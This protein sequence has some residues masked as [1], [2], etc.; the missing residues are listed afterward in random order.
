M[1]LSTINKESLLSQHDDLSIV[2]LRIEHY[3]G[4]VLGIAYNAPRVSWTYTH[5][6]PD[7]AKVRLLLRR[8]MPGSEAE[9][10]AITVSSKK[11]VLIEWPFEPLKSREEAVLTAQLIAQDGTALGP[12]CDPLYFEAGLFEESAHKADFVGPSWPE[13]ESDHRHLPLVRTETNLKEPPRRAR[14]YLS[15]LG[16]VE[17]EINGVK[18][19]NDALTPGWTVYSNRV[20]C[21]TYDVTDFLVEG[22]NALGFWLGDGWYRGRLGF[23]GGI[24]NYYGNR[25]GVSAQLEIEYGDH[26]IEYVYSNAWD[27]NWK[28][29]LGPIVCS[30]LYEGEHYDARLQMAGWSQPGFDDDGW[31]PVA[32]VP[33]DPA[34]IENPEMGAVQKMEQRAPVMI[35]PIGDAADAKPVW[36]VDMGQNCTQRI[37]LHMHDLRKDD[38]VTLHHVEVLEPDGSI[39]TRTLRRGQQYDQYISNG[40]DAW[41]EPRFTM[42]GFRYVQIEGI[43]NLS[44]KDIDCHVYHSEMKPIGS[45]ETSNDLL[46]KL[47][48]NIV[49]SMRSNFVSIPTDCPQRDE[50]MGWTGDICLFAPT[51]TYLY[52]IQGFLNSWLT[53]VAY[54]RDKW[55]TVPYFIPF[56]PLGGWS[57][58]DALA[59]WG[60]AAV[61]VPWSLFME[62]GDTEKLATTYALSCAWVD[63]V[64]GYLSPDGVWDRRPSFSLGQLGDW[65]DP[66]A[67][68]DNPAQAMTQKE[69][70]ATAFYARSCRQL[71]QMAQILKKEED[72]QR[73]TSLAEHVID[74]FNRRFVGRDGL[75]TSD[76]QCAYALSIEFDLLR[77]FEDVIRAGNRLAYL[78]D[79]SDGKVCTG[80]AGTPYVLP[81][82]SKTGHDK[83]AYA[84][85]ESTVCP[86]WLY[87]VKMGGTTTWE[88]WDSMKPDGS[89]N[90]G[91]MTSFNH[92]ALGSVANWMHTTIG[93]LE[94]IEPGWREFRVAPH[95]GGGI[96]HAS[97]SHITPRGEAS[98]SWHCRKEVLDLHIEVPVGTT[99][100]VDIPSVECSR[101]S[102]GSHDISVHDRN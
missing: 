53:D 69:L 94:A 23:D 59:I 70:V 56:V 87:Q 43:A 25:I 93:G 32:E 96:T 73:Y 35:K 71:T 50:R 49:W 18:V 8:R 51:V 16:M 39:A 12:V 98:V 52:D 30:D 24:A 62:S 21:W 84:L 22:R 74:G 66:S 101:L 1:A 58:P 19:G 48:E 2:D 90:P 29:T 7:K 92:Y 60:D 45:F 67:P 75:M 86:S 91:G 34:H 72:L 41:W 85:L 88:R 89:L 28:T 27:R 80:F 47:H 17:A 6:L 33:Y 3:A 5:D 40:E 54:E 42:H 81:A 44:E 97:T 37:R 61:A 10:I 38:V 9:T 78:V 11:S 76:T 102:P 77:R 4:N 64:A 31:S 46:N 55:G 15:A 68:P 57:H 79:H 14:L 63:E 20:E 95:M 100:V 99:C 65:L 13:F 36:I 26:T 82:L 83:Q